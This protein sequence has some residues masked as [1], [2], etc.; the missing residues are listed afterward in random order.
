MATLSDLGPQD[1]LAMHGPAMLVAFVVMLTASVYDRKFDDPFFAAFALYVGMFL[2]MHYLPQIPG[3]A[4]GLWF[5]WLH[6][7]W[8]IHRW[9]WWLNIIPVLFAL[10]GMHAAWTS[11]EPHVVDWTFPS[12]DL[13]LGQKLRSYAGFFVLGALFPIVLAVGPLLSSVAF[14]CFVFWYLLGFCVVIHWIVEEEN[15]K[16]AVVTSTKDGISISPSTHLRV[17]EFWRIHMFPRPDLTKNLEFK[18]FTK[19]VQGHPAKVRNNNILDLF[20]K[21]LQDA[22]H[23]VADN[24]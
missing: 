9:L 12:H 22:G 15:K 21:T 7:V 19:D 20:K 2:E 8:E 10:T 4:Q 16:K 23:V 5:D 24:L 3:F 6:S 1:P 13:S 18:T 11:L 14:L 17:N